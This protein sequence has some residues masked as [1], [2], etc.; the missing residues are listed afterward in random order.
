MI[1]RRNLLKTGAGLAIALT[2]CASAERRVEVLYAGSLQREMEEIIKPEFESKYDIR[3]LTE[4][5]T[6]LTLLRLVRDGYRNPDVIISA[7]ADLIEEF[8]KPPLAK[9]YTVFLANS[10]VVGENHVKLD[11]SIWFTQIAE[12]EYTCGMSD[13]EIDPLG[14][15]TLLTLKLA[16]RHYKR[17]FYEKMLEKIIVFG[18]EMDLMANLETE[19]IDTAF[20]YRNMAISHN[21]EYLELPPEIN[22]GNIRYGK[23]YRNAE[24]IIG[25]RK[26]TGRPVLYG[27]AVLESGRNRENGEIFKEFILRDGLKILRKSGFLTD[28]LPV[29]RKIA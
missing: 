17:T 23:Y 6:S 2:G 4:A 12:G 24:V 18:T 20:I 29:V 14:Y 25:D 10:I 26:I 21:L 19:S 8:L 27:I 16:E 13:P 15:N 9:E 5:R 7:D 28:G 22:L 11:G 1:S 3:C